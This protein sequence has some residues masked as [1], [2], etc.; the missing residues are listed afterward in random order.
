MVS[1]R[2]LVEA[3]VAWSTMGEVAAEEEGSLLA[4]DV[5]KKEARKG[6]VGGGRWDAGEGDGEGWWLMV[7]IEEL[8]CE[9]ERRG[10]IESGLSFGLL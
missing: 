1:L 10:E 3:G 7:D 5:G 8:A 4:S 2:H 6:K 9:A